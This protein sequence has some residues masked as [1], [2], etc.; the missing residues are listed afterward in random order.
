MITR[1]PLPFIWP[2]SH[3]RLLS[4]LLSLTFVRSDCGDDCESFAGTGNVWFKLSS[5]GLIDASSFYWASDKLIADGKSWTATVPSNIKPGKY[6]MRL[7]LLALHSAGAPQFYSSCTQLDITGSGTGAPTSSELVAIPGLY[8]QGDQGLFGSI[9]SQPKS[10]PQVGPNVAAFVSGGSSGPDP[11]PAPSSTT[12]AASSAVPTTSA[13]LDV[14]TSSD[15]PTTS[16]A[17]VTTKPASSVYAG[18]RPTSRAS[19]KTTKAP[20]T[21]SSASQSTKTCRIKKPAHHNAKR[22]FMRGLGKRRL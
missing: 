19:T 5:E 17:P 4:Q 7:E 16:D 9:W 21:A 12:P 8:K 22:A 13:A 18:P 2:V 3:S 15:V 14:P 1:D 11:V 6:L 10:W 20:S